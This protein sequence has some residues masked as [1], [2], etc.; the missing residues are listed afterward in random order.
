MT[1]WRDG[2]ERLRASSPQRDL[3]PILDALRPGQRLVLVTP[4][5]FSME[6]LERAVDRSSCGCAPRSS[7]STLSNDRRFE[8]VDG[9][10]AVP[11]QRGPEPG[12]GDGLAQDALARLRQ[13]RRARCRASP[14]RERGQRE[15]EARAAAARGPSSVERRRPCARRARGRSP[16]RARSRPPSRGRGRGRS[17]RRSARAPRAGRPGRGRR[18]DDRRRPRRWSRGSARRRRSAARCRSGSAR[19]GR[20]RPG[21]RGPSTGRRAARPR[22]RSSRSPARSPNSAATARAS[23]PSSTA[24]ERSATAASSR[25][26]SSSSSASVERR[27]SSRRAVATWRCAS[28]DVRAGLVEVLR[29][30]LHRALEHRQRRAQLVRRG[31]HER[32]PGRLL[33]AQLLLHARERAGEVADLV[34]AGV[35]RHRDVRALGRDPQ[36]R[37]AQAAERAAAACWRAGSASATATAR[38]TAAATSSALRTSSTALRDLGQAAAGDDHADRLRRRGRAARRSRRRRRR[39]I[40]DGL[41]RSCIAPQG[42]EPRLA[43]R[44]AALGVGEEARRRLAGRRASARCR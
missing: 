31:G 37:R 32:A 22:S 7:R 6:P 38:P 9:L 36:R 5:I 28:V 43:R 14:P 21:R 25:E 30:Q 26:R 3:K 10:P 2:V 13:R 17:A 16:A 42:G 11:A 41:L 18:P 4:I 20:P 27:S 24:S 44:R 8:P 34:V 39:T 23:S 35:A 15:R 12:R 33:A 19:R 40:S 1:D 29:E